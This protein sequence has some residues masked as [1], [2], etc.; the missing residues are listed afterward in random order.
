M[1]SLLQQLTLDRESLIAAMDTVLE[2]A[3][4]TETHELG[5]IDKVN[6]DAMREKIATLETRIRE[7]AEDEATRK[8]TEA[9]MA[10]VDPNAGK[11]RANRIVVTADEPVYR[12]DHSRAGES[13]FL[14]DVFLF[15]R[16]SGATDR[17][18]RHA[19]LNRASTTTTFG[20]DVG[21]FVPP[22]FLLADAARFARPQRPVAN[23][24]PNR[25]A[26]STQVMKIPKFTA[27]L[28]MA[29]QTTQNTSLGSSDTAVSDITVNTQLIGG[30]TDVSMQSLDMS[31]LDEQDL[32]RMLSDHLA[33]VIE[34]DVL[35]STVTGYKGLTQV[36][37][38]NT[39]TYTDGSKTAGE[40][41]AQLGY[42]RALIA[43]TRYANPDCIIVDPIMGA[44]LQSA[45]DTQGRPLVT[46]VNPVNALATFSDKS[47]PIEG[48]TYDL[49][50]L[51]VIESASLP[52]DSATPADRD[53][54]VAR[55]S[56]SRIWETSPQVLVDQSVGSANG[57]V[58]FRLSQYVA[59]T[60]ER[61]PKGICV[62]QGTGTAV[63]SADFI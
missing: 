63:T 31:Q 21:G 36:A 54:I 16:D 28:T 57:T 8:A 24:I 14:R 7:L 3:A 48:H 37:G 17:L 2:R 25:G 4:N 47:G 19:Q 12:E 15:G 1:N 38:I 42:A 40:L 35:S 30:Y 45:R 61:Q 9:V 27:G 46:P 20:G 32:F 44:W 51:P 18:S 22:A 10:T 29:R 39:V 62:V 6:Y 58:R 13:S 53:L 33:V 59:F 56:D 52:V 43:T 49:M 26:P 41:W 50:G 60:H 55:L 23:V 11:E 5:D 34:T